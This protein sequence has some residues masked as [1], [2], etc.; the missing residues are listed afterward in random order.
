MSSDTADKIFQATHRALCKHGNAKLTMQ[1]IA[2]ESSLST[3]AFHYHFET[4]DELLNAFLEH[5]LSRFEERLAGEA[6]D[7]C[8][9]LAT[10]LE[11]VFDP[12]EDRDEE[13]PIALF[14]IKA[15]APYETAY[16]KRLIELDERMREAVVSAVRDGIEAGYFAEADPRTVARFVVTAINGAHSRQVALDEDPAETRELVERYLEQRLGW[17]PGVVA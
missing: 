9:R 8:D 3:A 17:T 6:E 12:V 14:E 4:K 7:P 2:D 5:L 13:F 11:A 1:R 15:R 10:F 16:R